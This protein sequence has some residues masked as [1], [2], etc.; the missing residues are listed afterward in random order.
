MLAL[1]YFTDGDGHDK[2]ELPH[3]GRVSLWEVSLGATLPVLAFL[4]VLVNEC[5]GD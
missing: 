2:S 3:K 5:A 1:D 4:L